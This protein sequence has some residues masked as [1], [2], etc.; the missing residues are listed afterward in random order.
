MP[1]WS[2]VI[3]LLRIENTFYQQRTHSI[4]SGHKSYVFY[5]KPDKR[6]VCKRERERERVSVC[7]SASVW[8]RCHPQAD[9]WFPQLSLSRK[10]KKESHKFCQPRKFKK[11]WYQISY[12]FCPSTAWRSFFCV[13]IWNEKWYKIFYR[14]CPSTAWRLGRESALGFDTIHKM[15]TNSEKSHL[16]LPYVVKIL[17]HWRFR[18][19]PQATCTATSRDIY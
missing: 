17:A 16:Y 3:C 15:G 1:Q 11:K 10:S 8:F 6:C 13:F 18:T 9:A 2:Y 7:V 12:R 14:F 19:F 4:H 5:A